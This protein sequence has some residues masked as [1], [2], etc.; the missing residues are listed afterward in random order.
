MNI[1]VV[2]L[3]LKYIDSMDTCNLL[4]LNSINN[5][6]CN[7][8]RTQLGLKHPWMLGQNIPVVRRVFPRPSYIYKLNNEYN[9]K[10]TECKDK[11]CKV[12]VRLSTTKNTTDTTKNI[13]DIKE[14][15]EKEVERQVKSRIGS[16]N[17]PNTNK[18]INTTGNTNGIGNGSGVNNSKSNNGINSYN[19]VQGTGITGS[20]PDPIGFRD[21]RNRVE[22]ESN[23]R[24]N[25]SPENP[26][27]ISPYSD[28]PSGSN[29]QYPRGP[30]YSDYNKHN[31]SAP[32]NRDQHYSDHHYPEYRRE[33]R[34]TNLNTKYNKRNISEYHGDRR[35]DYYTN[36]PSNR[37]NYPD[38]SEE[39]PRDVSVKSRKQRR[40]P[41]KWNRFKRI[42]K[43]K[44]KRSQSD[45]MKEEECKE[46]C[47]YSSQEYSSPE[48]QDSS[49]DLSPAEYTPNKKSSHWKKFKKALGNSPTHLKTKLKAAKDKLKAATK[50][51]K[52][53]ESKP[54]SQNILE[55]INNQLKE[56]RSNL[57][58][59]YTATTPKVY[60]SA[61]QYISQPA[62]ISQN[63]PTKILTPIAA[64]KEDIVYIKASSLINT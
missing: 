38:T 24:I 43:R 5:R 50:K 34:D 22:I 61:P 17:Y 21:S 49:S 25:G 33:K 2:L 1:I 51:L 13:K 18:N 9:S 41:S 39:Y 19:G 4:L 36:T 53:T 63:Q 54:Q 23:R 40:K 56:I 20:T 3:L 46:D 14:E 15:I 31:Y 32:M 47:E 62:Y 16:S 42:F 44:P 45:S 8:Y 12:V 58:Q 64:P 52:T 60:S 37:Y 28:T 11:G 10:N 29:N 7:I 6:L 55:Q 35:N 59:A 48:Q 30:E 26:N 57:P 27:G